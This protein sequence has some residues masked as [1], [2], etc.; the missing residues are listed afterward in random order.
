M[1]L[2]HALVAP[3]LAAC[4]TMDMTPATATPVTISTLP[5]WDGTSSI[6]DFG[7]AGFSAWGQF[8]TAPTGTDRLLDFTFIVSDA[9]QGP[10][11]QFRAVPVEFTA[12]VVQYDPTTRKIVGPALYS[13]P[14]VTVPLTDALVFHPYTFTPDVQ[15]TANSVY[16]MFLYATNYT[17]NVPDDSRLRMAS[18]NSDTYGGGSDN[19]PFD[20]DSDFS[21]LFTSQWRFS[22]GNDLAFSATFDRTAVPEPG[23]MAL[24]IAAALGAAGARR[25]RGI[26]RAGPR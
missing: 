8:V 11:P 5:A 18:S 21:A 16:L 10:A 23:A 25:S 24:V 19:I 22:A 15:V 20:A 2:S 9:L 1:K 3:V 7:S 13:S 26:R 17:L 6:G 12:H 14:S 4:L